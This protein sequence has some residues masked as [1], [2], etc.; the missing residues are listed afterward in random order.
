MNKQKINIKISKI[1]G[2]TFL[3][4]EVPPEIEKR[5][6]TDSVEIKTSESWPGV[7]FYYNPE[8]T[9]SN[10]Y[11]SLL[12]KYRLFDDFGCSFYRNGYLNIAWLRTV[13]GQ[14]KIEIKQNISF[15]ELSILLRNTLSFIKE[16]FEEYLR[17]YE[18]K[19]SLTIEI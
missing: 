9:Q 6:N 4:Y 13:G 8:I 3:V 11:L 14:G 7:K 5:Y 2:K 12:G 10:N 15:A 17:D 18:V 19:G 1:N 16:Y